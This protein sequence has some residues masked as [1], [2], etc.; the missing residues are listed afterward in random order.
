MFEELKFP[1]LSSNFFGSLNNFELS[2]SYFDR[3][4]DKVV[5]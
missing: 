5:L 1:K 3:N 2:K 4:L